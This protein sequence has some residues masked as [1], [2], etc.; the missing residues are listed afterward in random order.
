MIKALA[1]KFNPLDAGAI[2]SI[3]TSMQNL[4]LL[5]IEDLSVYKDK[6]ETSIY[7]SH[8]L[9]IGQGISDLHLMYLVQLQLNQSRYQTDI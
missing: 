8:G 7:N 2:Q 9:D 4:T 6:L 5:D 3:M 1:K